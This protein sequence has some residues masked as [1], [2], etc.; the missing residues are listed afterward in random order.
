MDLAPSVDIPTI[1]AGHA[2]GGSATP[3]ISSPSGWWREKRQ[4]FAETAVGSTPATSVNTDLDLTGSTRFKYPCLPEGDPLGSFP[5]GYV[6]STLKPGGDA[7][8]ASW[9]FTVEF[10]TASPVIELRLQAPVSAPCLGRILVN[11][12]PI[13]QHAHFLSGRTAGSGYGVTLTFATSA[14]RRITIYSLNNNVGRFGGVAVQTGYTVAKPTRTITTRMA[15]IGDSFVN[16][17]NNSTTN[18]AN[19]VET[20]AFRVAQML[21]MDEVIL[22]GIG[23]TGFTAGSSPTRFIDRVSAVMAMSPTHVLIAGGRNDSATG[24]Q[25]AVEACLDAIGSGVT[26]WVTHTCSSS[27]ATVIAAI[28]AGC[29]S[30]GVPFIDL[31]IESIPKIAG[32]GVHPTTDGH[33]TIGDLLYA[34]LA[35]EPDPV[36]LTVA[37]ASHTHAATSPAIVQHHTISPDAT[38]HAHATTA[39]TLTQHHTLAPAAGSHGHAAT[40]PTLVQHHVITPDSTTQAHAAT[41][42][43]LSQAGTL[44]PDSTGH[45]HA[46]SSPTLTQHQDLAVAGST[47]MHV[48]TSPLLAARYA[49]AVNDASH[50][51]TATAPTLST[52]TALAA[53]DASHQ[54]AATGPILTQHHVLE[55]ADALHGHVATSPVVAPPGGTL[56][57]VLTLTAT[58][59]SL[60]LT[61]ADPGRTL[62]AATSP[63]YTLEAAP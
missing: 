12:K 13:A 42:P 17:A 37:D 61:A 39:P 29:A 4:G 21:G 43:A 33:V 19:I 18:G 35:P 11:G 50:G 31:D 44:T 46:A 49:L 14:L 3:T 1:S 24:E 58:G 26:R 47:H 52:S 5:S 8:V 41:S 40:S 60:T 36:S 23:S 54:H 27:Q 34:E 45:A 7:Q 30:R 62:T 56:P 2:L 22:A 59:P 63:T 25:A 15:I 10:E 55:V 51:H 57:A 6:I 32:D 53:A 16:G 28:A 9:A 38:A 48:A 20:F